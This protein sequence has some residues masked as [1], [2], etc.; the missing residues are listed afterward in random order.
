[1][2][3]GE[4]NVLGPKYIDIH[5]FLRLAGG[6]TWFTYIFGSLFMKTEKVQEHH[7]YIY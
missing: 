5:Q 7:I 3:F 1:M 6:G 2:R 4:I